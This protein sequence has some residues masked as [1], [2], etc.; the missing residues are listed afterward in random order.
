MSVT[1]TQFPK[2]CGNSPP[3]TRRLAPELICVGCGQIIPRDVTVVIVRAA[4]MAK[5]SYAGTVFEQARWADEHQPLCEPC[6][7]EAPGYADTDTYPRT[8]RQ[9][10][11]LWRIGKQ[12]G[13]HP[14]AWCGRSVLANTARRLFPSCSKRC[15]VYHSRDRYSVPPILL[16]PVRRNVRCR[17]CRSTFATTRPRE[18]DYCSNA[19]RQKAYRKRRGGAA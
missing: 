5:T 16:E 8:R 12:P 17:T 13:R 19:C 15:Q 2:F 9:G 6:W 14:C 18:A 4:R 3:V 1:A 7:N 10:E 11:R